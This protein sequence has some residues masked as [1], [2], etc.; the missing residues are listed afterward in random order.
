MQQE[1][2]G[3]MAK[4]WEPGLVK[5]RLAEG[6]GERR[7]AEVHRALV[8]C[9]VARF[10]FAGRQHVLAYAPGTQAIRERFSSPALEGWD[11]LPQV[12]G[13][14]GRRMEAVIA[15]RQSAGAESVVLLGADSPHLPLERID[16]AFALLQDHEVVLGPSEDGGYYLLGVSGRI[17]PI[18]A[19]IPW[20]TAN[21]WDATIACL[22]T[23]G[24]DYGE[25]KPWYDVDRPAD[26]DRLLDDLAQ[27][28]DAAL[29]GLRR[30]LQRILASY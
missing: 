12:E 1:C 3:L 19:G 4:Y 20:G 9:S 25:L 16:E 17:P 24:T 14:L 7:A 2:L 13:D 8:A 22:E 10:R 21:V 23:A 15:D 11:L 5:T 27:A 18:F 6:L 28:E 29:E 26:L 30:K